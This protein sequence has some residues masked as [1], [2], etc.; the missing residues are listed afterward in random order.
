MSLRQVPCRSI[1]I[2]LVW[3]EAGTMLVVGQLTSHWFGKRPGRCWPK[4]G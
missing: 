1:D 2:P 4:M 3:E